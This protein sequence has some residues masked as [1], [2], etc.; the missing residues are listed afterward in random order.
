MYLQERGKGSQADYNRVK[1]LRILKY[2]LFL[3]VKSEFSNNANIWLIVE[4]YVWGRGKIHYQESS[5]T[6]DSNYNWL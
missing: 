3:I 6:F 5:Q 2:K 1:D 4:S